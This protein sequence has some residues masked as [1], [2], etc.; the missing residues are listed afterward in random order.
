MPIDYPAILDLR[1]D[2][3]RASWTDLEPML[4]A[5][6]LGMGA[7]PMDRRELDFVYERALKVVPTFATVLAAAANP[8]PEGLN[9][10]LVLDGERRLTLHRPLPATGAVVMD[11]RVLS[12]ID[13]GDKGAILTREVVIRDASDGAAIATLLSSQF[14]RGDGGFGGP[15]ETPPPAPMPDQAPDLTVDIPTRPDQALLYRLSGDRNPL[16]SDPDFAANAKFDRPILH[17]LCTFGICCRA[18][19]QT[20]ADYDPSA[21][22]TFGARFSA[23]TFPGETVTVDLWRDGSDIAFEAKVAAR[24]VAVIRNGAATLN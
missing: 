6:G 10:A 18:I 20:W 12:V 19:L 9:R 15:S 24:G 17:G 22:K 2:G 23:P 13:K 4:Y 7:D 3:V 14:A 21:I 8:Q 16:H 1:N 5:L 11:G